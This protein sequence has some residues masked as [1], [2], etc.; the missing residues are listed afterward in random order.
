MRINHHFRPLLVAACFALA[1][2]VAAIADPGPPQG[3]GMGGPGPDHAMMECPMNAGGHEA[4]MMGGHM[5][6]GGMMFD[7]DD[8]MPP[9]LRHLKLTETQQDKIFN[10][11]HGQ[12]PQARE[13]RK[14][15]HHA[16]HDLHE[17]LTGGAY[18]D[19]KAK[20]LTDA[21]GKAEADSALLHVRTH[22]QILEVLTPEQRELLMQ[23]A[24]DG[25]G[26]LHHADHRDGPVS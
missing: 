23:H 3:H 16:H 8:G 10:I 24:E 19:A 22:H 26:P 20:K 9:P 6:H 5:M 15:I 25:H 17:L 4:G 11:L 18:D 14:A 2:P 12:A 7:G 21:L 13:L 1:A